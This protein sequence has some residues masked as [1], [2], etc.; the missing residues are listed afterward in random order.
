MSR[1]NRI[2]VSCVA[3]AAL[4]VACS[5][6]L[7]GAPGAG[8]YREPTVVQ[9][10]FEAVNP[11]TVRIPASGNVTWENLAADTRGFVVFPASIASAF[12]CDDLHP[13]FTRMESVYRSLPLTDEESER[14]QLPCPLAPG[15]YDYEIWL[16]GSGFGV[17][18]GDGKPEHVLRAKIVVE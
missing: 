5:S 8:G 17:D 4:L 9:F 6:I 2:T 18:F 16:M 13:Y 1:A 14:V 3:A 12:R 11:Q 15:S 10:S 7:G